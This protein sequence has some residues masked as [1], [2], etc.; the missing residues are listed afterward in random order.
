M[1]RPRGTKKQREAE[2]RLMTGAGRFIGYIRVSTAGQECNGH[3]LDGQA[4]RLREAAAREGVDLVREHLDQFFDVTAF[5]EEVAREQDEQKRLDAL[6][7][8]A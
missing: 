2:K 5:A 7:R 8:A 6:I 3:S 4:A 1:A